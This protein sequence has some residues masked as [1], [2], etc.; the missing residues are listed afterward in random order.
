MDTK[1]N[2]RLP[3]W[4]ILILA[5]LGY[6][7]TTLFHWLASPEIQ[8][9]TG[10]G[11]YR[12]FS[13]LVYTLATGIAVFVYMALLKSRGMT[14]KAAGYRGRLTW[15][16]AMVAVIAVVIVSFI[17]Y[18]LIGMACRAASVPMYWI[19]GQ[20]LPVCQNNLQDMLLGILVTVILAPLT[21]DTIFR[22]YV[23]QAFAQRF[24]KWTA[25]A[26]SSL[27]FALLHIQFFGPGIAIWVLF[28]GT[29]SAW[30][31][32]RFNNI[33]PSLLFHAFNN[34]WAYIILPMILNQ[35]L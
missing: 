34:L 27:I 9:L 12:I 16:G 33:Y 32:S 24:N 21:E 2:Q 26:G 20:I 30:L 31:Y 6:A 22:G 15:K 28:F 5:P 29:A 1:A 8:K 13:M 19:K 17:I 35:S 23:Y 4:W 10:I 18:P 7:G 14:M 25:I 3:L 11:Q